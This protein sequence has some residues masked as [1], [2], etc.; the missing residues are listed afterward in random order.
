MSFPDSVGCVAKAVVGITRDEY[1]TDF[2]S[3]NKQVPVW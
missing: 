3:A 1:L 2:V